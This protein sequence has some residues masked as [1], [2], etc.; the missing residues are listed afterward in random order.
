MA[1]LLGMPEYAPDTVTI[2]ISSEVTGDGLAPIDLGWDDWKDTL[3]Q[4]ILAH[5]IT[6]MALIGEQSLRLDDR[7]RHQGIDSV[8]VRCFT[9]GQDKAQR[10]SLIVT[11]GVDLARKAAS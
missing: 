1:E 11:A 8:I 9:A 6:I 3:H 4:Q 5:G 10:A 2:S 7:D